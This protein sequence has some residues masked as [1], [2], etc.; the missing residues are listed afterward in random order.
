MKALEF[1]KKKKKSESDRVLETGKENYICSTKINRDY[2]RLIN[3]TKLMEVSLIIFHWS[4]LDEMFIDFVN[5]FFSKSKGSYSKHYTVM[6]FHP[7]ESSA[8][9]L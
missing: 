1:K 8:L 5:K 7:V 9:A 6:S 3:K 4:F 2:L